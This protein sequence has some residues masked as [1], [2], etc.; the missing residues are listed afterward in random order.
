M[1]PAGLPQMLLEH[2]VTNS[3]GRK[4]EVPCKYGSFSACTRTDFSILFFESRMEGKCCHATK[5]M[6][7]CTWQILNPKFA[8]LSSFLSL[9]RLQKIL[10]TKNVADMN[11]KNTGN[12]PNLSPRKSS[13]TILSAFYFSICDLFKCN[14]MLYLREKNKISS[15]RDQCFG[16]S[17]VPS[18]HALA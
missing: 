11:T 6:G 2:H 9:K 15:H 7:I 5:V 10:P 3:L 17:R 4:L 16:L 14:Q 18:P 1:Q 8:H 13:R 12:A